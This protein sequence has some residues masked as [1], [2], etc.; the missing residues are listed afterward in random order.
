MK[1]MLLLFSFMLLCSMAFGDTVTG[2]IAHYSMN[3]TA[4]DFSGNNLTGT[5]YGTSTTTDRFGNANSALYF[6]GNDYFATPLYRQNYDYF[7][8]SLW[9]KYTGS[10]SDHYRALVGSNNYGF[11]AGSQSFFIGKDAGNSNL[12]VQDQSNYYAN[13]MAVG[14]N[15]WN[16]AWHNVAYTYSNGTGKLYLDGV[17]YGTAT[18]SKDGGQILLGLEPEVSGYYFLGSMDEVRFYNRALSLS[19]V[20]EVYNMVPEPSSLLLG[21][22]GI[23]SAFIAKKKLL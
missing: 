11:G 12:G 2:L 1:K 7:T 22:L 5:L 20:V 9:F 23:F 8:V 6:D 15:A 4:N 17:A 16:G 3:G 18:F 10:T 13:T 19:D 14:T 21:L